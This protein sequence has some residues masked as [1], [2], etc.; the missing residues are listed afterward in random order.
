MECPL[1]NQPASGRLAGCLWVIF[2]EC[3]KLIVKIVEIP[4][5]HI[6]FIADV[7]MWDPMAEC[8]VPFFLRQV[9]FYLVFQFM[10][11]DEL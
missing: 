2:Y 5:Q 3:V 9:P 10:N 8:R 4:Q 11:I 6:N 1:T 7:F